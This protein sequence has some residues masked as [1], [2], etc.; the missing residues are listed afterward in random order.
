MSK[1]TDKEKEEHKRQDEQNKA[2]TK[3]KAWT[4]EEE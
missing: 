4:E 3:G 2:T 1:M